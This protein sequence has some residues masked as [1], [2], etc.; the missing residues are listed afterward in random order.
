MGIKEDN[1]DKNMQ[2]LFLPSLLW[3][4]TQPASLASGRDKDRYRK[5]HGEK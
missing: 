5:R 3:Q 4:K 2:R 1:P